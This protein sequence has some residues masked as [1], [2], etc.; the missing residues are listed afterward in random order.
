[1]TALV[2]PQVLEGFVETYLR[3]RYDMPVPTPQVH[4][5]WWAWYFDEN[6]YGVLAAPRSHAKSTSITHAC[7]L[8]EALQGV[9]GYF[10]IVSDTEEQAKEFLGD[11][12]S[13]L[14]DNERLI[15][16][17]DIKPLIKDTETDVICKTGDGII[18]RILAKGAEQKIRG[19]KWQGKRPDRIIVDDLE[20]D[21]MVESKDRRRKVMRW[22]QRALLPAGSD[23]CRIRV[24]G[25]I[26]HEDALLVRL[27]SNPLWNVKVYEAHNDDF[28]KILWEDRFPKGRL[29][30]IRSQFMHEGDIDGYNREYRNIAVS[31]EGA[32]FK[33]EWLRRA[34]PEQ[35]QRARK[36][37]KIIVSTDFQ[38]SKATHADYSAIGIIALDES[39]LAFLLRVIR[40][41]LDS[42]E[43]IDLLFEL[44][45]EYHPDSF[46][47]EKG[48]I[49]KSIGP[50]LKNEMVSR[51]KYLDIRTVAPSQDKKARAKGIQ[52]ILRN[53]GMLFDWDM[54][55]WDDFFDEIT[56]F[57]RAK[58]DDQVDM[59][60]LYGLMIDKFVAPPDEEERENADYE[61]RIHADA[62]EFD[63]ERDDVTGY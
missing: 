11:I 32:F 49:E 50:I 57:D 14:R 17:F 56:R 4:R 46:L 40:T 8:C 37:G 5:E 23:N 51:Q 27:I 61:N 38:V 34:T 45:E 21:E 12:K 22:F 36:F 35:L 33:K 63:S 52:K 28:S 25:T 55:G 1:M 47:I 48:T 53:G 26:L 2:D 42:G 54:E 20:N 44:N 58:Y 41:R 16:D 15:A 62:S 18:F 3:H 24:L 31:D 6:Q 29:M 30:S 10:V 7:I 59:L 43:I 39:G 60:S 13:E 19:R 9:A